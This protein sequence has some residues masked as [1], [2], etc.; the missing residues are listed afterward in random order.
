MTKK[1][2]I[3][4]CDMEMTGL[5]PEGDLPL[6]IA[7]IATDW[8]LNEIASFESGIGQ[9]QTS[10]AVLLDNN[11]FYKKYPQNRKAL[12]KLAEDSPATA[13]VEKQ[14]LSFMQDNFDMRKPVLLA[15]NS[16]HQD[17]RFIRAYLPF[18]DQKLHYRMLDVTA[19][20]VLFEGK[21]ETKYQK[22]ESHRALDDTRESIAELQ[23]YME[24]ITHVNA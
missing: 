6:E 16:I 22:K 8:D 17:R 3:L 14:L 11:D 13:V 21:Y 7:V 1:A 9:D 2:D 15:G 19:W 18:F 20:K 10:V 4:W 23:F 12:L 24:K 5:D